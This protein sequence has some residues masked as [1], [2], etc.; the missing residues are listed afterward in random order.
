[1]NVSISFF[2]FQQ[3]SFIVDTYGGREKKYDLLNYAC[4]VTFFPQL[5][6]GPIVKTHWFQGA[7]NWR[8]KIVGITTGDGFGYTLKDEL[9]CV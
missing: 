4:F 2:T 7:L 1:M 6:A 9:I 8:E 3:I 5:I